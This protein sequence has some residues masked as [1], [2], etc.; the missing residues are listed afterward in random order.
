[1]SHSPCNRCV[2]N[3]ARELKHPFGP[4][5][6][7]EGSS[8]AGATRGVSNQRNWHQRFRLVSK[9]VPSLELRNQARYSITPEEIGKHMMRRNALLIR[10]LGGKIRV[11][12]P[13]C[14]SRA[15]AA[16]CALM[17]EVDVFAID[18]IVSGVR[19][20][21]RIEA[22][23]GVRRSPFQSATFSVMRGC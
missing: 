15:S 21:K 12:D 22:L 9:L 4:I 19:C 13:M 17:A 20:A 7:P 11:L 2:S 1:M 5:D 8:E 16:R 18:T 6:A 23:Y 3:P 14:G 10:E